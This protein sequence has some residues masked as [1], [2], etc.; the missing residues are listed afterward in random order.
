MAFLNDPENAK[1]RNTGRQYLY[2]ITQETKI[3]IVQ[4]LSQ[5]FF[6]LK[7]LNEVAKFNV[8]NK[9]SKGRGK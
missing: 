8:I 1:L 3:L 5:L 9:S 4:K 7:N 6:S 2:N